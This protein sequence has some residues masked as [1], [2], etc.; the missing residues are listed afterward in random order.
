MKS[1]PLN[2]QLNPGKRSLITRRILWAYGLSISG[3][4]TGALSVAPA[5]AQTAAPASAA[6]SAA[7]INVIEEIVVTARKKAEKLQDVPLSISA[8]TS[9]T[10]ENAGVSN[11]QD[12][13]HLTP[14]VT[15]NTSGGESA[16]VPVIRGLYNLNGGAGDPNVAVFLDGIY[17]ANTS[18]ISLGLVDMERIEVIKGPV[19]ALYGRNAYAGVINYVTKKPSDTIAASVEGTLGSDGQ[20]GLK[21][22]F[23]GPI[24]PGVLRAGVAVNLD[25]GDGTYKDSVNGNR[26]G[27]YDKRDAQVSLNLTP[28]DKITIDGSVYHGEDTFGLPA[29]GYTDN[30]CGTISTN[31][32]T[33]PGANGIRYT[34]Y[35]GE[36]K[37][38]RPVEVSDVSSGA[39]VTANHRL[40]T[41]GTLRGNYD[42]GF[43]DA[44][45]LLGY[46]DVTQ[47]RFSDFT[48]LRNG[49]PFT[50]SPGPGTINLPEQFG[51]DNNNTDR[52]FELRLSSKQ[53]QALRWSSGLY[54]YHATGTGTTIIGIDGSTLPAGQTIVGA[55][56]LLYLTTNGQPS[57]TSIS[58]SNT[59][60]RVRS[61]YL[62]GEY[63]ILP[64]L[65]F[66]AEG[67]R[68]LQDKGID[69]IR[70]T[71][72]TA[73]R[74]LGGP[75]TGAYQY[76]NYRSSLKY[77]VTKDSMV[78]LSYADGTKGGGFNTRA[79]VPADLLFAP[80]TN[81]TWEIGGKADFFGGKLKTSLAMFDIQTQNLQ[82]SGPPS[83][84]ASVGLVT[85]NFGG[86]SARGFE[87]EV[88][89]VPL[90]GLTVNAGIGVSN[91]KFDHGTYDFS[92]AAVCLAIASCASR[93]TTISSPQ[94]P[95]TVVDMA[96]LAVPRS[97]RFTLTGGAQYTHPINDKW[98][99]FG[100]L[101]MRYETKQY[102]ASPNNLN[103]NWIGA[104]KVANLHTGVENDNWRITL[105]IN[106]LTNDDTP[107]SASYNTRLNDFNGVMNPFMTAQRT[108]GVTVAYRY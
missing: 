82:I 80:E 58:I 54:T 106:N 1:E 47:R 50:L 84:P 96:G 16:I 90:Q 67:R 45:A 29:I 77:K 10:L 38:T 40:V 97:S 11:L 69:V 6:S 65:T 21:A 91:P 20:K 94:G 22:S 24:Q 28:T 62:S 108:Y 41:I 37:P 56:P 44:A 46:T 100:R 92:N 48:G 70:V 89:A 5:F 26:A 95:R 17:L 12:L 15:I 64:D 87:F 74:P 60:E 32:L 14:G 42:L 18:A 31:P 66:T 52:S 2:C 53:N 72:S 25:R 51:G 61:G 7:N 102:Q 57:A 73:I 101:D 34:Q 79:T 3:A 59:S 103:F 98:D 55:T 76:N 105:F 75:F 4:I 23:S 86:V 13:T 33:A 104:R 107:D 36:I 19:S 68:T 43:A 49:I 78:Y 39:G 81:K 83:N 63:D 88:A 8:F 27:A 93:V 35:C 9:Q 99:G 30:N 85:K 71:G